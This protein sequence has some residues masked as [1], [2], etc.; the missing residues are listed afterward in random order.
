[1]KNTLARTI[2]PFIISLLVI[3]LGNLGC[4]AIT[5]PEI[6]Y[7][8]FKDGDVFVTRDISINWEGVFHQEIADHWRRNDNLNYYYKLDNG[9]WIFTTELSA[10]LSD[11]SEGQHKLSIQSQFEDGIPGP[12]TTLT[13]TVDTI[14]GPGLTFN[15][16]KVTSDSTVALKFEDVQS[17][18]S[19]HIEIVC[20]NDCAELS[21]FVKNGALVTSGEYIV[22]INEKNPSRLII[23]LAFAGNPDGK[24]GS[25]DFGSFTV[26]P[27]GNGTITIDPA[28]LRFKDIDN[29]DVPVDPASLDWIKVEQ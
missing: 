7:T 29:A 9:L 27:K 21:G 16:R 19:A 24:S 18:M 2:S 12:P 8:S 26:K 17:I 5:E 4:R 22:L 28:T 20:D 23:D 13:F 11:V 6:E 10:T 3:L 15:P 1:M 14:Q 25:P